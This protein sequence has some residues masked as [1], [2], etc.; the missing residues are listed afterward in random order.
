MMTTQTK[1]TWREKWRWIGKVLY[2]PVFRKNKEK[3]G[4]LPEG[5]KDIAIN[6]SFLDDFLKNTGEGKRWC[7]EAAMHWAEMLT[8]SFSKMIITFDLGVLAFIGVMRES[9]FNQGILV[10]SISFAS[11]SLLILSVFIRSVVVKN[12]NSLAERK[13]ILNYT[14]VLA[15]RKIESR[16]D[17]QNAVRLWKKQGESL[18]KNLADTEDHMRIWMPWQKIGVYLFYASVLSVLVGIILEI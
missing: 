7:E 11:A 5:E 3:L 17:A 8:L 10:L 16:D 4:E 2:V 12:I 18:R 15:P 1:T 13:N 6:Q 9:F 14:I